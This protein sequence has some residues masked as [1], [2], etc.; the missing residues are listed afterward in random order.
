VKA[1]ESILELGR[2]L[3]LDRLALAI[4]AVDIVAADILG[5]IGRAAAG[6][7]AAI[8]TRGNLTGSHLRIVKA[9]FAQKGALRVALDVTAVRRLRRARA[10]VSALP[11]P[12]GSG[13]GQAVD[14]PR[15]RLPGAD[16]A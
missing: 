11:L 9:L 8:D 4:D 14:G 7:R 1:D 6:D 13:D 15:L 16:L 10:L 12:A 5:R 3:A 2:S